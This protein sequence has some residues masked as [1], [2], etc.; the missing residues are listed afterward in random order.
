M[1][2]WTKTLLSYVTLIT[3]I[4]SIGCKGRAEKPASPASY[5]FSKPEKFNMPD[6][7][8]EISGL[9]FNKLDPSTVY[10][11]Q[12]E[13]GYVFSQRWGNKKALGTKFAGKGDFEDLGILAQFV[14]VLKSNGSLYTFPL[15]DIGKKQSDQV[16]EW[17]KLLPKGEY[18]SLYADEAGSKLIVLCKNCEL[19]RNK[20]QT[21]GYILSYDKNKGDM[22]LQTQFTLNIKQIKKLGFKIGPGLRA[23]ALSRNPITKDWYILSAVDKMLVVAN[24]DWSIK[25][26]SHLDPGTFNQPEGLA[27]D[28][29]QN[30]YISNEGDEIKS[31]NILKFTFLNSKG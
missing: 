1:K 26:V 5:D 22:S 27:F 2:Q 23:S 9:A 24:P 12:D 16:K 7:L 13:D 15:S 21:T 19:D 11:I 3:V 8:E 20:F 29:D 31:G 30:L 18:E 4:V 14:F 10:S 17:K 25:S 28:K 6:A